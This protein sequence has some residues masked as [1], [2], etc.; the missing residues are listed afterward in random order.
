MPVSY[1]CETGLKMEEGRYGREGIQNNEI[2]GS[3]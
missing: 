1:P 2:R 3:I